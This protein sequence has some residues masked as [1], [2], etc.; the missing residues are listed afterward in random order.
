MAELKLNSPSMMGLVLRACLMI[1]ITLAGNNTYGQINRYVTEGNK[2]YD[3][4]RYKEAAADYAKALSRNPNHTPSM[5]NLGNSLYQQKQFDSSRRVMTTAEKMVKDKN[6]KAAANY[7]IGNTYMS[8]QK[9][10]DAI[11]AY[12]RTKIFQVQ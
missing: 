3:Q 6:G 7:N 4:Q 10:E 2:F 8:E 5:F 11:N 1:C 12:K 9:W